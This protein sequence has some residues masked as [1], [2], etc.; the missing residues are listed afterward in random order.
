MEEAEEELRASVEQRRA[1]AAEQAA[2]AS[3]RE[4][5]MRATLS[6]TETALHELQLT[7]ADDASRLSK[8]IDDWRSQDVVDS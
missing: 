1:E 2:A 8:R 3:Q 5:S 4:E 7:S 6:E